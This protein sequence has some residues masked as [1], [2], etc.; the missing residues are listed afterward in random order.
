VRRA[1]FLL[2]ATGSFLVI[3]GA[4]RL[5]LLPGPTG[6]DT[7]LSVAVMASFGLL[8]ETDRRWWPW[9][10]APVAVLLSLGPTMALFAMPGRV[11]ALTWFGRAVPYARWG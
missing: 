4:G 8:L 5:D 1:A 3:W 7:P 2:C 9:A 11:V 6:L 10:L